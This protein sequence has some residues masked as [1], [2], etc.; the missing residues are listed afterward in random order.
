MNDATPADLD[1]ALVAR[2]QR[3]ERGAFDDLVRRH[4]QGMWRLVRRY[5]SSDADA[6]DVVQQAFVR[7]YRAVERFR[8]DASVRSWL[9]RIAINVAL[10]H[11]RDRGRE[12]LGYRQLAELRVGEHEHENGVNE[13]ER[14]DQQ[15]HGRGHVEHSFATWLLEHVVRCAPT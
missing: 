13:S 3:G 15:E 6:A 14:R 7:A 12:Q 5:V 1:A 9:Y 2:A 8:G 11:V 10:N 4:Q